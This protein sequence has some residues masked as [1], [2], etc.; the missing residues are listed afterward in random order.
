MSDRERERSRESGVRRWVR[1]FKKFTS[2]LL[3]QSAKYRLCVCVC[4]CVCVCWQNLSVCFCNRNQQ[5]VR[6]QWAS[7][8][9]TLFTVFY[10]SPKRTVNASLKA[11]QRRN[12]KHISNHDCVARNDCTWPG[13]AINA[14]PERKWSTSLGKTR[15]HHQRV[16][17]SAAKTLNTS[18]E[19]TQVCLPSASVKADVPGTAPPPGAVPGWKKRNIRD[20]WF[21]QGLAITQIYWP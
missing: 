8:K 9:K 18:Q 17:S 2:F 10:S 12:S 3:Q 15:T 16:N 7:W 4:V 20:R 5:H 19:K 1:E 13:R 6:Q 14:S 21:Y 11:S